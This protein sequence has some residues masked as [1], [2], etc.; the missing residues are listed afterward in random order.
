MNRKT[1]IAILCASCV[2]AGSAAAEPAFRVAK[3]KHDAKCA[4]SLYYDDG[5]DSAFQY[6]CDALV[7]RSIPGTFY[8]ICGQAPEEVSPRTE[9]WR[10]VA[11]EHRGIIVLGDHTWLHGG[12]TN[13]AQFA[14][15][16]A[17]NGALVRELSGLPPTALVSFARPGGV[18]WEITDEEEETVLAAHGELKR[19]DFG[20]CIAGPERWRMNTAAKALAHIDKAEADGRWQPL[21]FHGVG[22]DWFNFPAAE[23]ERLLAELDL[24]RAAGRVWPGSTIAVQKYAA[25]R[26][27]ARLE[28]AAA[29]GKGDIAAAVLS[30]STDP[31]LYDEPLTVVLEDVPG[32]RD[33]VVVRIGSGDSATVLRSAVL[34]GRAVFNV[35]PVSG[36]VSI[37]VSEK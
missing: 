17:R 29:A 14:A 18:K 3:W 1:L 7:R 13:A 8:L 31:A 9:R 6:V 11:T 16:I 2:G 27:G 35:A 5:T 19:H 10:K 20:P 33:S 30:F 26:D 15:D 37:T 25:E 32:A 34:D 22:A 28:P 24:R 23:H 4:V 12:T 36:S 21:L